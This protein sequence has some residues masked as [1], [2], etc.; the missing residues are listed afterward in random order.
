MGEREN[1]TEPGGG[2]GLG[3]GGVRAR[4]GSRSGRALGSRWFRQPAVSNVEGQ[5]EPQ[6]LTAQPE[7]PRAGSGSPRGPH[8]GGAA[9][10]GPRGRERLEPLTRGFG[11]SERGRAA[12]SVDGRD[13]ECV[14]VLSLDPEGRVQCDSSD[15]S[16]TRSR[17][18]RT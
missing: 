16:A 18:L 4:E 17:G 6:L 7:A 2:E 14:P 11:T 3:A 5:R 15:S 8:G 10:P 12:L 1:G 9:E 13:P